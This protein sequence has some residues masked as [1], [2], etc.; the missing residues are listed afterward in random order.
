MAQT[1]SAETVDRFARF[2]RDYYHEDVATLAQN[3]PTD[4]KSIA[5]SFS[6][7]YQFDPDV[8]YDYLKGPEQ[9]RGYLEEGLRNCDLPD[10]T[11]LAN[12]HVRVC[13]LNEE[14]TYYPDEFSPTDHHGQYRA[15]QGEISKATDVYARMQTAA[16]ECQRC[17]CILNIP[18]MDG[19]FQEPHECKDCERQGPFQINYSQS[20]F[21]D[22]QKLRIKTPPEYAHGGGKD[23]DGFV[24]D[25]LT[26]TANVGDRVTVCG[27]VELEQETSGR[28]K[29]NKFAPYLDIHHI[30]IDE[31][32]AEDVEISPEER[33]RIKALAS[34]AEGDPLELAA[35]SIAPKI[36][37]YQTPK[38][39]IILALV[40][41]SRTE[42]ASGGFDRGE[43]HVLLIGDPSTAKS[44]LVNRAEQVGW[45][46]VGVSGKGATE[47]GVTAAATQDDF[48]DGDWTLSSGAFV[49][50]NK[51]VVCADELD[52]M[53]QD[54][55]AAMLEPMSKQ[56]INVNKGGINT[57][58]ETRTG[59]IAAANPKHGRFD[60]YEPMADQFVFGGTL[61]SRF[62]LV[63]TFTDEPDESED[64]EVADH[65]LTARDAAKREE[66]G[67][68]TPDVASVDPPVEP[69]LLRHWIALAKRQPK[70]V[71]ASQEV[72]N[73]IKDAFTTLRGMH[74]YDPDE[75]VPVTFR[76]L[77]GLVRV[78][79]AIAKFE[80]SDEITMRHVEI[81][82]NLVGESM[83]DVGK[84]ADGN[85]DADTVE[86]GTSKS[87]RD[88]REELTDLIQELQ[89]ESDAGIAKIDSVIERAD[90]DESQV[91]HDIDHLKEHGVIYEPQSDHIK[92]IGWT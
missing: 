89:S 71:F 17:G 29:K 74:G 51:G 63:Y 85:Y 35:E 45:R 40:G 2:F 32:D 28:D 57:T 86:T 84:D 88:R 87:Q 90:D 18:Q 46:T 67:K 42:Y 30:E 72:H 5:V 55:R 65:I 38:K 91:R 34:G 81:A 76:S 75:P 1:K 25:D 92:F 50:A 52:D 69:D 12:V 77:E 83:E 6:D 54:V 24:E 22:G 59:V 47:A 36:Y 78:A 82:T 70:P 62:D 58:L 53:P 15:V 3:Y 60:P 79:E 39:A 49:K 80:F 68:E 21:V 19:D 10:Q 20:E 13:N 9:M 33:D 31:T 56:F 14:Y 48:G 64:K 11:D 8:A 66:Q 7:L 43:F 27:Q 61:L 73:Q 4:Q 23:I 26:G 41:G 44:K 16:F 37:G